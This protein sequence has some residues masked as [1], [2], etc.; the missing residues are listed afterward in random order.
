MK[1][2]LLLLSLVCLMVGLSTPALAAGPDS[3]GG[4]LAPQVTEHKLRMRG[5]RI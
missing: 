3:S 5:V 4:S 1:K 2:L